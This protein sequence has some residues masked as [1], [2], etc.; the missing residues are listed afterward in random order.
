MK[1]KIAN[2]NGRVVIAVQRPGEKRPT[3]VSLCVTDAQAL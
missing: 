2:E 1:V 3:E